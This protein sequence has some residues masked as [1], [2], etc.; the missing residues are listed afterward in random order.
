MLLILETGFS[1]AVAGFFMICRPYKRNINNLIDFSIFLL[2]SI[3][4]GLCLVETDFNLSLEISTGLLFVPFIVF[5]VH[6]LYLLLKRMKIRA[7]KCFS[8]R[9]HTN[10]AN[11]NKE[12]NSDD[13]LLLDHERLA[14][15]FADRVENPNHYQEQHNLNIPQPSSDDDSSL[16]SGYTLPAHHSTGDSRYG[17][18]QYRPN[19]HSTN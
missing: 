18:I 11:T 16:S 12:Q 7:T 14:A 17:S 13:E 10:T 19:K 6:V 3:L 8:R 9:K 1:L 2:L 5:S 15:P 4:S